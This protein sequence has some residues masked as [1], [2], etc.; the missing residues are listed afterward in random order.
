MLLHGA[1]KTDDVDF[2]WVSKQ[3]LK[4]RIAWPQLFQFPEQMCNFQT[5]DARKPIYAV[6][7]PLTIDFA[8]RN[9]SITKEDGRIYDTGFI[10]YD[11]PMMTKLED[12]D[13]EMILEVQIDSQGAKV[14]M[15]EVTAR[16]VG[17][18][19]CCLVCYLLFL[20]TFFS[21]LRTLQEIYS[22]GSHCE[23]RFR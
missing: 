13:H 11:A 10:L 23:T 6:D 4:F 7:H 17:F 8:E 15:L 20:D 21:A 9:A 12:L 1:A 18:D 22:Q 14:L 3:K 16:Y 5:D 2:E 19:V